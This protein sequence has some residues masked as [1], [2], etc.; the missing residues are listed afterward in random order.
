MFFMS[1]APLLVLA[2]AAVPALALAQGAGAKPDG[3]LAYALTGGASFLSGT[4]LAA[5]RVNFGGEAAMASA[6]RHWRFGGRALW[7]RTEAETKAETVTL[8]LTQESRHRWRGGTWFWEKLSVLPAM[9]SSDTLRG[10]VDAGMAV[11]MSRFVHFNVGI[12]QPYER[13]AGGFADA[14]FVTQLAMR[15]D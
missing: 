15:I 8:L 9:R 7:A 10:S 6:D 12:S 11:A 5:A 1:I 3:R 2:L 13:R 14:R 4:S